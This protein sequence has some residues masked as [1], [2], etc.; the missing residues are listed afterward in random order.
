LFDSLAGLPRR[1]RSAL[2]L[3]DELRSILCHNDELLLTRACHE[4]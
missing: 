3:L 1:K 2:Q 4:L